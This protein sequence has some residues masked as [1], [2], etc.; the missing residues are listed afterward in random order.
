[1]ESKQRLCLRII[2]F[3]YHLGVW[4]Y[5]CDCDMHLALGLSQ[6]GFRTMWTYRGSKA[7]EGA[8]RRMFACGLGLGEEPVSCLGYEEGKI[9]TSFLKKYMDIQRPVIGRCP[10]E[11]DS[12][13]DQRLLERADLL[14]GL[15]GN[16]VRNLLSGFIIFPLGKGQ[17]LVS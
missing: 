16:E 2:F 8:Q 12:M 15:R 7:F 9:Y 10:V 13:L 3:A 6:F 5:P 11:N 14:Y 4:W 1:M 17:S